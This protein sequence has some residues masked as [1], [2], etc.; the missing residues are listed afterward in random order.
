MDIR[1][2]NSEAIWLLRMLIVAGAEA[3]T[4]LPNAWIQARALEAGGLEGEELELALTYAGGKDWLDTGARPDTTKLT[5]F[6]EQA[7]KSF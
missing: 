7:A 6:G 3:E 4:P 1:R 5:S 2:I